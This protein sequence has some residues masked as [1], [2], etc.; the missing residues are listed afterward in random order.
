MTRGMGLFAI[1]IDSNG[2]SV[3][4]GPYSSSSSTEPSRAACPRIADALVTPHS[5]RRSASGRVSRLEATSSFGSAA[6]TSNATAA[7]TALPLVRDR[8][9]K[10]LRQLLVGSKF[11]DFLEGTAAHELFRGFRGRDTIDGGAGYDL[12]YGGKGRDSLKLGNGSDTGYGGPGNDI[13]IGGNGR[14]TL[15]GGSGNDTL[16]VRDGKRDVVHCGSDDDPG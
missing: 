10:L 6:A 12:A 5:S 3:D 2:P 9:S 7:V 13:L 16:S 11:A 14:D 1:R 4:A 8:K 15:Y